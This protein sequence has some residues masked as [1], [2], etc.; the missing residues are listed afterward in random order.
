LLLVGKE[1]KE[2]LRIYVD[3]VDMLS[4]EEMWRR[5]EGYKLGPDDLPR[6]LEEI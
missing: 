2:E 3:F 6:D 5:Q 4:L 1:G